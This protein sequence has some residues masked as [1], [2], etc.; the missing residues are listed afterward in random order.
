MKPKN[1][2]G[3]ASISFVTDMQV[4]TPLDKESLTNVQKQ[5][6][7]RLLEKGQ[8]SILA[9]QAAVVVDL[10]S[11]TEI[12]SFMLS[13]YKPPQHAIESFARA[14]L[15]SIQEFYSHEKNQRVFEEWQAQQKKSKAR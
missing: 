6:L 12:C 1:H 15:P 2:R 7:S 14:I 5:C 11:E 10:E 8:D 4:S 13:S 9:G 3:I